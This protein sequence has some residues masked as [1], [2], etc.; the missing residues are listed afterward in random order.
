MNTKFQDS[1]RYQKAG[2]TDEQCFVSYF[3]PTFLFPENKK[4]QRKNQTQ[5]TGQ[6]Q[7][8]Q[9][10]VRY[11]NFFIFRHKLHTPLQD[12][13]SCSAELLFPETAEQGDRKLP[14]R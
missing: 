5:D 4:Q 6:D 9:I 1:G 8:K 14:E 10:T 11:C 2:S 3:L 7:P 12:F 13:L